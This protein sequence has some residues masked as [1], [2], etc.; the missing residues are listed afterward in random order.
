MKI[1]LVTNDFPPKP[2]GIQQYLAGL[3][4]A[5]EAE[6]EVLAPA[7]PGAGEENG[8]HRHR[9]RFMWPTPGVRRWVTEH[10]RR[11]GPDVVL[12][13]APYPLPWLGPHLRE[14]CGTPYAVLCHGAEITVPA[15]LPGAR[16]LLARPLRRA[17]A[18]AAVS[19]FTQR[20]VE[21]L[22]GR[23]VAYIGGGVD[24]AAFHPRN[25]VRPGDSPLTLGIASRFVPRKHHDW[26][27]EAAARLRTLGRD[28][29]VLIVGRGRLE[30]R[31][32]RRADRL[33]VP[34]RFEIGVPWSRLPDLYRE[35]DVFCMPCRSRWFGLEI[36][37]LG[38]VFLE[39]AASG[40]PVLAGD[41]GGAP[42]T[43]VPGAT[44]FIVRSVDDIVEAITMLDTDRERAAAMGQRGRERVLSEFTW[45]R[46]AQRLTGAISSLPK[47]GTGR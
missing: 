5:L 12:F 6:I 45:D 32:R 46:V 31:L 35:M 44:G 28:V 1:L 3:T 17:D 42:E 34:A 30:G 14:V 25:G 8:V 11:F 26:V 16:Q 39:G 33:G 22:T 27:L 38:L 43:V 21:R 37:G 2:G 4:A 19:R 7:D 36:E 47:A 10:V 23:E 40:L 13:G 24:A 15:A 9:R 41:S 20:K 29:N 18:V